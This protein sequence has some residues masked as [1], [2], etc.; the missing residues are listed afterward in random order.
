MVSGSVSQTNIQVIAL[1]GCN[2]LLHSRRQEAVG[3]GGFHRAELASAKRHALVVRS[4][5]GVSVD[6]TGKF[7][8]VYDCGSR[9][10]NTCRDRVSRFAASVAQRTIDVLFLSHFDEDHVN[11]VPDL[12]DAHRGCKVAT[13]VL[14][15][16]DDVERLIAFGRMVSKGRSIGGFFR[17]LVINPVSALSVFGPD[18]I[19]LVRS[20]P[21]DPDGRGT[22]DLTPRGRDPDGPLR[23]KVVPDDASMPV[24][25]LA[26]RSGVDDLVA[27]YEIGDDMIVRVSD[28]RGVCWILK[29]YVRPCDPARITLFEREA[30]HALGWSFGSF[31][32]KVADHAV[33]SELVSFKKFRKALAKA[34]AL[35]FGDRNLTSLC[36]Y[37]GPDVTAEPS[38]F[39][40][41]DLVGQDVVDKVGWLGTGDALLSGSEDARNLLAHYDAQKDRVRT[42]G[43]PHHGSIKNYSSTVVA[44]LNPRICFVSAKPPWLWRHPHPFVMADVKQQG[45]DPRHIDDREASALGEAF[46]CFLR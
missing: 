18:R 3:Q 25:P 35:A 40:F 7:S 41:F 16:V 1:G 29:P 14:P 23:A 22:I 10:L 44:A 26:P 45:A 34:Y 39:R 5:S 6:T 37:S 19:L 8:Y 43:L 28:T 31:R 38:S 17:S 32:A 42:F 21:G 11:A 2:I 20:A 36:L 4:S 9:H 30:E 12:L 33:R 15:F 13:V 27:V 46:A 24:R